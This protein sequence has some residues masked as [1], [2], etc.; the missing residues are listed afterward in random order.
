MS[1]TKQMFACVVFLVFATA[2][3]VTGEPCEDKPSWA[4]ECVKM[5]KNF[6]ERIC[7]SKNTRIRLVAQTKCRGTC[8]LCPEEGGSRRA[9]APPIKCSRTLYGC[10]WDRVSRATGPRGQGCPPC[11]NRHHSVCRLFRWMCANDRPNS[12][13]IKMNCPVSCGYCNPKTYLSTGKEESLQAMLARMSWKEYR[14]RKLR[15]G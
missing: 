8:G 7:L 13:Y 12:D 11:L 2:I 3:T 6:G 9:H 15:R 4:K 10:C 14:E 1:A 5:K